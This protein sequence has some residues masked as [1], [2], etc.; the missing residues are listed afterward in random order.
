MPELSVAKW[1]R[2]EPNIPGNLDLPAAERFFLEVR[3]GVPE[4]D[5]KAYLE[6][7]RAAKEAGTGAA[8]ATM[9]RLGAVP[10]T[11]EGAAVPTAEAYV[12]AIENQAGLPLWREL[13]DFVMKA[14]R[15]SPEQELF[16]ARPSGGSASTPGTSTAPGARPTVA[17]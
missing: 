12:A 6:A 8:L 14:N 11:L 13:V 3:A 7:L 9:A 1:V 5:F 4:A 15:W 10:L 2:Y 17:P 16:F